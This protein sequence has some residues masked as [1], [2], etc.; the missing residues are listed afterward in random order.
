MVSA[1]ISD[2]IVTVN[3]GHFGKIFFD[4]KFIKFWRLFLYFIL[5]LSSFAILSEWLSPF[6]DAFMFSYLKYYFGISSLIIGLF[7]VWFVYAF[8]FNIKTQNKWLFAVICF[9]V[10]AINIIIVNIL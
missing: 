7:F 6:V 10:T 3:S 4:S 5:L 1:I 2:L 8:D 9:V